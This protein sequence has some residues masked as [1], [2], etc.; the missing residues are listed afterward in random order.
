MEVASPRAPI[1]TPSKTWGTVA[2]ILKQNEQ[3]SEV[4]LIVSD[5]INSDIKDTFGPFRQPDTF[6]EK[7][8]DADFLA[9]IVIEGTIELQEEISKVLLEFKDIFGE[10]S[11]I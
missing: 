1:D 7:L 8:S 10:Y 2:T 11:S 6:T 9:Q 5:E 4:D 3:L